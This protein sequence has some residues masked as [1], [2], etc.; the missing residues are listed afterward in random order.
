MDLAVRHQALIEAELRDHRRQ[1]H[2]EDRVLTW[3]MRDLLEDAAKY[4]R[5]AGPALLELFEPH[6]LEHLDATCH[7]ELLERLAVMVDRADSDALIL[8][9]VCEILKSSKKPLLAADIAY[10][11]GTFGIEITRPE[12]NKVLW[13]R[14]IRNDLKHDDRFR[15]YLV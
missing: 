15:W 4:Y 5:S 8:D 1:W 7:A 11:L 9:R 3:L 13:E 2:F 14:N 6:K 10:R 12:L